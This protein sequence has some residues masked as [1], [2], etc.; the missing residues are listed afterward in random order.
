MDDPVSAV[1]WVYLSGSDPSSPGTLKEN[2][3]AKEQATKQSELLRGILAGQVAQGF[4]LR[5][6]ALVTK[7]SARVLPAAP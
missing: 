7:G 1:H 2:A 4:T 3:R 5:A 6:F